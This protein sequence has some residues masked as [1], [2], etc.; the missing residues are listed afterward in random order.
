MTRDLARRISLTYLADAFPQAFP[1]AG[2]D[3][4]EVDGLAD[5]TRR[6]G[7]GL[8]R[9][10]GAVRHRGADSL[11]S[12][13]GAQRG[14]PAARG[15]GAPQAACDRARLQRHGRAGGT[16]RPRRARRRAG[17]RLGAARPGHQC[18]LLVL[19]RAAS[20]DVRGLHRRSAFA[21]RAAAHE[22]QAQG[23]LCDH[24]E[25]P[26]F[27]PRLDRDH[28]HALPGGLPDLGR[29]VVRHE[30]QPRGLLHPAGP[31]RR[32]AACRLARALLHRRRPAGHRAGPHAALQPHL[33]RS[34]SDLPLQRRA[35]ARAAAARL[36]RRRHA[37][38]A[39]LVPPR[40]ADDRRA[41]L[42]RRRRG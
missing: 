35:G 29:E 40:A 11:G 41:L 3:R 30:R 27:G 7:G 20:L 28:R 25:R 10:R 15:Q 18:A 19:L 14:Q 33:Q 13:G 34:S 37:V 39:R 1:A 42:R 36:G 22:R 26:R 12:G 24:R 32:R 8:A 17:R 31:A 4:T 38:L 21:L 2:G 16:R 5:P 23:M 6:G 9:A